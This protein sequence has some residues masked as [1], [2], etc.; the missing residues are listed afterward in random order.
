MDFVYNRVA[1]ASDGTVFFAPDRDQYVQAYR[2]GART[3]GDSAAFP[4]RQAHPRRRPSSARSSRESEAPI[5][6]P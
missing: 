2:E 1:T 4:E 5:R 6:R 3:L